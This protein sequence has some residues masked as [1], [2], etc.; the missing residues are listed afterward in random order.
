MA[1]QVLRK[2][3]AIV[4][5]PP[6]AIGERAFAT[7]P[8][9]LAMLPVAVSDKVGGAANPGGLPVT[10]FGSASTA[11]YVRVSLDA[12][13]V[14]KT[15][16]LVF[17]ARDVNLL[18]V[19]VPALS[20]ARL[21]QALPNIVEEM[22]LQDPQSCAYAIGP[23]VDAE[24]LRLVAAI[25]RGWLEFVVGAFE[26]RGIAVQGA[27]P[28]QLALPVGADRTAFACLNDGLALRTGLFDGIGWN[29]ASDAD[30]RTEAIVA[31]LASAGSPSA[32]FAPPAADVAPAVA[33]SAAPA[34]LAARE[35]PSEPPRLRRRLAVFVEDASWQTPVL[36]AAARAGFDADIRALPFPL[37][38]P[39]DL[40]TARRGSAAG[41]WFADIDW[42]AWRA[43]ATLG[44]AS[45]AAVLLG[46]N[47]HWGVLAQERTALKA[48]TERVFRQAFPDR[49]LVVEPLLQMQREVA[50]LRTRAGQAGPDD[51][52]PL[53]TRFALA[54]GAQGADSM[55]SVEF[56]EARLRVRFQPGF[57]EA[58]SVREILVRDGQRQ[59]LSV[60][61]DGER[62]P[63]ATVALLR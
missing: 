20:G 61:F 38:A 34:G 56:R 29:A 39:L 12:L 44:G 47:L 40:L 42:R 51:F 25:D 55:A 1:A 10:V 26:R 45:V 24:G 43:A 63:T 28:A 60:K 49:Q 22:L 17:D 6:R 57:F 7:E 62:E 14:L 27:W 8:V 18:Q 54:L 41:R 53:L 59:G 31:L 5:V 32:P 11:R 33:E 19:V 13:P 58:R 37:P 9:L 35:L 16:T 23:R 4:W 50:G 46:L 52:L 3:Q 21:Q 2:G 30:A 36:K 48:Q 15:A